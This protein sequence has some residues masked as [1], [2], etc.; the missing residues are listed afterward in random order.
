M[1][2]IIYATFLLSKLAIITGLIFLSIL[3]APVILFILCLGMLLAYVRDIEPTVE[4][5]KIYVSK[6][7]FSFFTLENVRSLY[8]ALISQI[9]TY[10]PHVPWLSNPRIRNKSIF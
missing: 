5:H 9:N 3:T 7:T 1:N 4:V 10:F 8:F 6:L 2:W